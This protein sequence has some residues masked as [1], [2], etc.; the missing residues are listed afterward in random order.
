ME[1]PRRSLLEV[2]VEQAL[3]AGTVTCLVLSHL[4]NITA[5]RTNPFL[6]FHFDDKFY[7][8]GCLRTKG[9]SPQTYR[10]SV[11]AGN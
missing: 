4:V 1:T 11:F 5:N 6:I 7:M 3:E 9:D 2:M 10:F 8:F